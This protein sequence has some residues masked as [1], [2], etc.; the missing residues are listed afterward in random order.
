MS[1][2]VD[3]NSPKQFFAEQS[4]II[5]IDALIAWSPKDLRD[6]VRRQLER[7]FISGTF[8][9][10]SQ[11]EAEILLKATVSGSTGPD[12]PLQ[13]QAGLQSLTRCS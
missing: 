12:L 7:S 11:C 2:Q 5:I 8:F 6:S 4:I 9:L 1:S 10:Q 13:V 3:T